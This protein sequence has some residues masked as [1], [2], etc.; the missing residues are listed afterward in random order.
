[1]A[2]P[3]GHMTS[4]EKRTRQGHLHVRPVQFTLNNQQSQSLDPPLPVCIMPELFLVLWWWSFLVNLT[5]GVPRH[6]PLL[7]LSM[8]VH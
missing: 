6:Q 4:L 7:V 5:S 1:M 8:P 3:V 2:M